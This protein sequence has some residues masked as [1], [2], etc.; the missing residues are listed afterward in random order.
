MDYF[1]IMLVIAQHQDSESAVEALGKKRRTKIEFTAE[2]IHQDLYAAL[3]YE[4]LDVRFEPRKPG[5]PV[6]RLRI[7]SSEAT[8]AVLEATA[9][10]HVDQLGFGTVAGEDE[11]VHC[12]SEPPGREAGGA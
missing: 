9:E 8:A 11:I 12:P 5:L 2:R 10:I 1:E 6:H 7:K 4:A 3:A